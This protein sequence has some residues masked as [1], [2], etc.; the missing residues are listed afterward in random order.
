M[1]NNITTNQICQI[2]DLEVKNLGYHVSKKHK[3][4]AK[5][6]YDQYLKINT[7]DICNN[8]SCDNQSKFHNLKFGYKP[9]CSQKCCNSD[10]ELSKQK[11]LKRKQTYNDN[12]E[13]Q[14]RVSNKLKENYKENPN[15][16]NSIKRLKTFKENPKIIEKLIEKRNQTYKENPGLLKSISDKISISKRN[17]YNDLRDN[18]I[19]YYLYL[20]K[21]KI[22]PI[23]KIGITSCIKNRFYRINLHFGECEIIHLMKDNYDK[24]SKLE[25]YLHEHFNEYCRVQPTGDGRT[26]WFDNSILNQ[27]TLMVEEA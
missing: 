6:Y 10:I 19:D 14:L 3:I 7:E 17:H 11:V 4:K 13:I 16:N 8:K 2:C 15:L 21:H 22:K 9:Y 24:I 25:N 27:V 1:S 12:P 5:E 26:E 20:I 23:F 18:N